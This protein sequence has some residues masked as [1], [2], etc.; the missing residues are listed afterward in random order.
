MQ[1]LHVRFAYIRTQR[2]QKKTVINVLENIKEAR[3]KE[4]EKDRSSIQSRV[5]A[6]DIQRIIIFIKSD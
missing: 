3:E 2:E 1:A 5:C 4:S 6:R